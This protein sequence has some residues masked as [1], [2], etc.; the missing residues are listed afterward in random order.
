M[1]MTLCTALHATVFTYVH[2]IFTYFL[3]HSKLNV[4]VPSKVCTTSR[5]P[6]CAR[7]PVHC[8]HCYGIGNFKAAVFS[9]SLEV[10][11]TW[12]EEELDDMLRNLQAHES[13][14]RNTTELP[15]LL[16]VP[17]AQLTPEDHMPASTDMRKAFTSMLKAMNLRE[18]EVQVCFLLHACTWIC[19]PLWICGLPLQ[20][21]T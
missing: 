7:L 9:N 10:F 12:R 16:Q 21:A 19:N 13:F 4:Q 6:N 5:N 14:L 2:D 8:P 17:A 1:A 11:V 20:Y 3:Q 18:T 15:S